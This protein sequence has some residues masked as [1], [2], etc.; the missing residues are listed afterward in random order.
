[1]EVKT[2]EKVYSKTLFYI[3]MMSSEKKN[4]AETS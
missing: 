2:K 3:H 4:P 1:L